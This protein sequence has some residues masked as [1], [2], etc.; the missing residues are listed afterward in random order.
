MTEGMEQNV[1][2]KPHHVDHLSKVMNRE[3]AE[4]RKIAGPSVPIMITVNKSDIPFGK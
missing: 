3:M 2:N 1:C 4:M